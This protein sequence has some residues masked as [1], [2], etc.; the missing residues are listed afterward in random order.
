MLAKQKKHRE[1]L[2]RAVKRWTVQEKQRGR[3]RGRH[4]RAIV[5]AGDRP[6]LGFARGWIVLGVLGYTRGREIAA[7][8]EKLKDL[9]GIW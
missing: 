1:C 9:P 5:A 3:E 6:S 2:R 4:A 7:W 8:P